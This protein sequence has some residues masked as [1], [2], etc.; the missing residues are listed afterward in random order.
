MSSK[1][2]PGYGSP[3]NV[4]NPRDLESIELTLNRDESTT[5]LQKPVFTAHVVVSQVLENGILAVLWI[6]TNV[7]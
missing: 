3:C 5:N 6:W 7:K 2:H 1:G 4:P